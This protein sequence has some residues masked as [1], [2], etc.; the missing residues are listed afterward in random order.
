[1]AEVR[2]CAV[3]EVK[4][5]SALRV[6]V[7]GHRLAVVRI[8]DDAWYVVGD[9]CTHAEASLA[10]G[11]IWAD[12]CEIECPKHGSAFSL[13]TGQPLTLPATQPVPVYEVRVDGGEVFVKLP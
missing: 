1:M 5:N 9:R 11:E 4:P 8:G 12:E 7:A 10:G 2:V 13:Q 3:D 6:D